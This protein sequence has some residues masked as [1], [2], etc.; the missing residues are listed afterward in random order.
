[1]Y[2]PLISLDG[3]D[4]NHRSEAERARWIDYIDTLCD[5]VAQPAHAPLVNPKAT[6][7]PFFGYNAALQVDPAK[8]PP[9]PYDILYVGHNWWRWREVSA[10]LLPAF[11][12]MRDEVGEIA[13][14]GLWWDAPPPEGPAAGPE[15]AFQSDPEAFRRLKIR[16]LKAVMY[17]DVI[18]TMSTA[19]INIFT[20]RPVLRHLRHLTLK[21]FEVFCA[22][23]IPMLMLDADHAEAVFGPAAR[24]LVLSDPIGEK[25]LDALR[26][27]DHYKGVVDDVRR[28]LISHYSYDRRVEEL[29]GALRN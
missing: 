26:R 6:S 10:R 16:T 9:K 14:A 4:S 18:W 8:A 25:L 12:Q 5:R 28:H 17:H 24:E 22:D 29:I 20:Q 13:F 2:N 11:E 21:Y 15:E 1:M 23:T 27:P 19:R 7:L 3:Y